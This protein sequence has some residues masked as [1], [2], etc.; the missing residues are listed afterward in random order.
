MSDKRTKNIDETDGNPE[1]LYE[2]TKGH[3]RT[4]FRVDDN[5]L[6]IFDQ[7]TQK[8]PDGYDIE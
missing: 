4:G 8:I 7:Q 6:L 2:D 5:D 1:T 3:E